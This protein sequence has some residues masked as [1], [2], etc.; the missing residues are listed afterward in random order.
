MKTQNDTSKKIFAFALSLSLSKKKKKV[1]NIIERNRKNI[2]KVWK[3]DGNTLCRSF[4]LLF[5]GIG[6]KLCLKL[7]RKK[8]CEIKLVN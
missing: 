3:S 2:I 5:Y 4:S 7:L 8:S 1:A 6:T